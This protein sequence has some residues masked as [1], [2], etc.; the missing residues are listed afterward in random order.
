ME[1]WPP[2]A[3]DPIPPSDSWPPPPGGPPA[4]PPRPPVI[5][6]EQPGLPWTTAL[7]ATVKLLFTQPRVAFERMPIAGDVLRPIVFAILIGWVGAIFN[8]LWSLPFRSMMP[9]G[10]AYS[11]QMPAVVLPL[12]AL[13]APVIIVC[14]LLICA[15]IQHLMLMIV[16]GAKSGFAAT[17]RVVC[18]AQAPQVL[19]VL[20]FCG[21]IIA[22]V[23]AILLTIQGLAV[24]HRISIG[25][26]A[27]A[28]LLPIILCCVCICLFAVTLGAA[29]MS[30]FGEG[31]HH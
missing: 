16:G 1:D 21:G 3:P 9:A 13:F 22:A 28:V 18:Y 10:S 4:E 12:I 19:E 25:K 29:F 23:G 6:W 14:A 15:V 26:A 30:H 31:L 27:L 5:P 20:P 17:L 11:N 2:H 7:I 8:Y 24:A